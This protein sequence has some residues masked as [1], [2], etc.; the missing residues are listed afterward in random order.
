MG[1]D[2][3]RPAGQPDPAPRG[4]RDRVRPDDG[5][6]RRSRTR[7]GRAALASDA[8]RAGHG[9]GGFDAYASS[10]FGRERV[11]HDDLRER[12]AR[13]GAACVARVGVGGEDGRLLVPTPSEYQL[14]IGDLV[15]GPGTDYIIHDVDGFG[16]PADRNGD[17]DRPR[18]HGAFYGL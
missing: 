6:H 18:D 15:L 5:A 2:L 12:P 9:S 10:G 14:A 4:R 8:R 16:S 3:R 11:P 1:A 13:G 17:T 7:S